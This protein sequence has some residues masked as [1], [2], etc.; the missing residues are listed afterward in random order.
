M[1]MDFSFL[2]EVMLGRIDYI[3]DHGMVLWEQDP[4]LS[5]FK[6]TRRA[7]GKTFGFH[8][9]ERASDQTKLVVV[10]FIPT[11]EKLAEF[12][13]NLMFEDVKRKSQGLGEL[14]KVEVYET[15][16]CRAQ[17]PFLVNVES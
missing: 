3:C 15:P 14:T 2:K 10:P 1:V 11:A 12:W 5:R 9:E 17:Y 8:E 7:Y 13:F 16:Y 6:K 4:W